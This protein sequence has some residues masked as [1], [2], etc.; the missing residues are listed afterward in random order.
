[1]VI[2]ILIKNSSKCNAKS[3]KCNQIINNNAQHSHPIDY[4][5]LHQTIT[6]TNQ[7]SPNLTKPDMVRA[8]ATVDVYVDDYSNGQYKTY[9][10]M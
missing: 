5:S 3:L 9:Y 8:E 2:V 7:S 6:H 1:M 4:Q 10:E